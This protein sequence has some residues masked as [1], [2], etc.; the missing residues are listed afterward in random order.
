[1]SLTILRPTIVG[2]S[3]RDPF[4][5]W[6]D[7]MIGSSAMYFFSGIGLIKILKGKDDITVD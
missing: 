1:M 5:G 3:L 7:N 6:I 4:P 2:C